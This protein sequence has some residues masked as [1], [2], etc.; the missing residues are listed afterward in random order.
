MAVLFLFHQVVI[1]AVRLMERPQDSKLSNY[2]IIVSTESAP[3]YHL[4][5]TC[6]V[7]RRRL[8]TDAEDGLLD[9][10]RLVEVDD[11]GETHRE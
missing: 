3:A 7:V 10:W 4:P 6:A 5:I 9:L 1:S 8:R 2:T 11:T